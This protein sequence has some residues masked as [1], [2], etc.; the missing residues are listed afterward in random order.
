MSERA[1]EQARVD[2]LDFEGELPSFVT[3]ACDGT[4]SQGYAPLG[5]EGHQ[6]GDTVEIFDQPRN[7][8]DVGEKGATPED[9]QFVDEILEGFRGALAIAFEQQRM[10]A[11][12]A[13]NSTLLDI[14]EDPRALSHFGAKHQLRSWA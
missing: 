11:A 13:E 12:E 3:T 1:R 14:L 10:I 6:F 5:P 8:L 2:Q 9:G 7:P 4:P